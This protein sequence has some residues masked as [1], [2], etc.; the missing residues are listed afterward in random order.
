MLLPC[1]MAGVSTGG[2]VQRRRKIDC[3]KPREIGFA[4][5]ISQRLTFSSWMNPRVNTTGR[6]S[7]SCREQSFYRSRSTPERRGI[8]R[9]K[10]ASSK[11]TVTHNCA[12][13]FT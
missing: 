5:R 7:S 3:T 6:P 10:R 13:I 12:L 2:F 11:S 1:I 8:H 9:I 4:F